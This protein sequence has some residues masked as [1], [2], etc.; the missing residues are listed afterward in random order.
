MTGVEGLWH[1]DG[2]WLTNNDI[3]KRDEINVKVHTQDISRLIGC[4]VGSSAINPAAT[5]GITAVNI[6]S[7]E[8][9][10][11]RHKREKK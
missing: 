7:K 9:Q 3:T 2:A 10:M 5:I 1:S 8:V 4:N 6:L 11:K